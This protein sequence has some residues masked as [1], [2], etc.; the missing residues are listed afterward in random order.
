MMAQLEQQVQQER[1]EYQAM[2]EQLVQQAHKD[3]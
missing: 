2:T 1:K 3:Q